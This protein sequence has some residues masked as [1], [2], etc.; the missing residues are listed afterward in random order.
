MRAMLEDNAKAPTRA[1][2][3]D[4]GL[5]LYSTEA[6]AVVPGYHAVFDTGTHVAI[7]DG[8]VGLVCPRSGLNVRNGVFACIGVIDA[9]YTGSIRVGLYNMGREP[10]NVAPGERIAQLLVLPVEFP[11]VELVESLDGTERGDDGFGSTGR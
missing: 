7:P 4:A 3:A 9:G 5:D 2:E 6:G 10:Y 8:C 11:D 1:H